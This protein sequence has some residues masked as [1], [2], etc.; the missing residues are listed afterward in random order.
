[1]NSSHI[2]TTK[3]WQSRAWIAGFVTLAILIILGAG[4]VCQALAVGDKTADRIMR[5][6][7]DRLG[8]SQLSSIETLLEENDGDHFLYRENIDIVMYKR[9][10]DNSTLGAYT[11]NDYLEKNITGLPSYFNKV[12][13]EKIGDYSYKTYTFVYGDGVYIKLLMQADLLEEYDKVTPFVW[14]FPVAF[15]TVMGIYTAFAFLM[16]RPVVRAIN[17]QKQF[18][19]EMTH[20]IRTPLTVIRGNMENILASPDST[21]LQVSDLLENTISEVEHITSLSQDLMRS[22][23]TPSAKT[24]KVSD[25]GET[26]SG[27]LEIYSEIIGESNRTLIANIQSAPANID[28]EKLKQLVI[29]LLEN[30]VKYTRE[31]DRI[32]VTLK[33]GDGG[34]ILSVADTGIG[35][36]DGDEEKIFDR[37]FRGEN[38]KST[39][40]TGLGLAIAKNIV[41]EV[42][43]R[44][45]AMHNV[46]S[47]IVI[48]ATLPERG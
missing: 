30:S 13:S 24:D 41:E 36:A 17:Q 46:P 10:D 43:G 7:A 1:M 44:I 5:E 26:V 25:A 40:G 22:V 14:F 23:S 12:V 11:S 38:A 4:L 31:G 16:G 37:F 2:I 18:I 39:Q 15:V 3:S 29:I 19:H 20:E 42:G 34:C 35:I 8:E 45:Y 32:K 9:R 33:R 28:A 27:V 47:G 6:Y 21:V 48:T